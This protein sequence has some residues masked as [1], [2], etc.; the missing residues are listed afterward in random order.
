M[1]STEDFNG[2]PDT[3]YQWD[4]GTISPTYTISEPGIYNVIAIYSEDC[5]IPDTITVELLPAPRAYCGD[6]REICEGKSLTLLLPEN[7]LI[8][9]G[10]MA[11]PAQRFR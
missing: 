2:N 1:I 3:Q 4:D 10:A 9:C 11:A 7:T 6:N 5:Q 8:T